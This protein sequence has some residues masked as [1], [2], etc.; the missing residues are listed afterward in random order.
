MVTFHKTSDTLRPGEKVF[1]PDDDRDF[2][3]FIKHRQYATKEEG[4]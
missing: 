2:E 4:K 1:T 3:I